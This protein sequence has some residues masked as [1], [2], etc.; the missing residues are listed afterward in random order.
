MSI[1]TLF[2]NNTITS[3]SS[4]TSDAYN[5]KTPTVI[6]SNVKCRWE[7][8]FIEEAKAVGITKEYQIRC[9]ILPDLDIKSSYQVV[10]E[11]KI[12]EVVGLE[13]YTNIDGQH[14]HTMMYLGAVR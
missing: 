7:E 3:I 5:D 14:D 12:Y 6:Y 8:V 10:Y 2:L 4:T 11:G 13:K 9:W 1:V